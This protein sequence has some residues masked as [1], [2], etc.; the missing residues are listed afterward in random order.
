MKSLLV[1]PDEH[2]FLFFPAFL[3]IL[4]APMSAKTNP[5]DLPVTENKM[6]CY[7]GMPRFQFS[8]VKT[9]KLNLRNTNILYNI[10]HIPVLC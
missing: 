5:A 8:Q 10:Q 3:W 4:A 2:D 7:L 6:I 1:T 9:I